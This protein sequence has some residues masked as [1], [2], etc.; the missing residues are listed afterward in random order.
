MARFDSHLV[1]QWN[2]LDD[3]LTGCCGRYPSRVFTLSD[4][5][6]VLY[7]HTMVHGGWQLTKH[8]YGPNI[9]SSFMT[10]WPFFNKG[11]GVID[12]VSGPSENK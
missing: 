12:S 3:R 4:D 6:V 1:T 2:D 8:V 10:K 9:S 5:D 11:W 7:I